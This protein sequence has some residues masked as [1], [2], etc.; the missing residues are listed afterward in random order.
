MEFGRGD[1]QHQQGS[2]SALKGTSM[3]FREKGLRGANFFEFL[4]PQ[5]LN[6]SIGNWE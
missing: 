2:G 6:Y 4:A 1:R 3:G 5:R